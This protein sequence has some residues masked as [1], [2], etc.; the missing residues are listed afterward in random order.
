[1]VP[2]VE[3]L[4]QEGCVLIEGEPDE[5]RE[6]LLEDTA[7]EHGH[8]AQLNLLGSLIRVVEWLVDD[9]EVV[10]RDRPLLVY[11]GG[12]APPTQV[13]VRTLVTV[14]VAIGVLP[15]AIPTIFA[16]WAIVGHRL[17][18]ALPTSCFPRASPVPQHIR[19]N[20]RRHTK[21]ESEEL[22]VL[23]TV[24]GVRPVHVGDVGLDKGRPV[25]RLPRG[26]LAEV[27]PV[28]EGGTRLEV[29][30]VLRKHFMV[31]LIVNEALG[32]WVSTFATIC[33]W[34]GFEAVQGP[35]GDLHVHEHATSQSLTNHHGE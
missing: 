7:P 1:M 19:L 20:V 29:R 27:T 33:L 4:C 14:G 23:L 12:Q 10:H 25:A 2:Q 6:I 26:G 31:V 8:T 18:K 21:Q 32:V 3:L 34:R 22:L 11:P 35:F 13:E 15:P 16:V 30:F 5:S 28:G 9:L 24:P 17:K